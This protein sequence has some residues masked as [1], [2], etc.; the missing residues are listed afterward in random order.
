MG[1]FEDLQMHSNSPLLLRVTAVTSSATTT[2]EESQDG[3]S[4]VLSDNGFSYL[5][6]SSTAE[7]SFPAV[8][9][10]LHLCTSFGTGTLLSACLF[11][12]INADLHVKMRTFF[13]YSSW[14]QSSAHVNCQ[15]QAKPGPREQTCAP[16]HSENTFLHFCSVFK[17]SWLLLSPAG[18]HLSSLF[19]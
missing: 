17:T 2:T 3:E 19:F 13:S 10:T 8:T 14:E 7:S 15:E 4:K 12:L 5:T 11:A 6:R 9:C 16:S 1:N 18:E